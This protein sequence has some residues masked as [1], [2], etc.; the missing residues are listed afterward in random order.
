MQN[1]YEILGTDILIFD[2]SNDSYQTLKS[3]FSKYLTKDELD[4]IEK[5]QVEQDRINEIISYTIPKI[6]LAKYEN[7]KAYDVK[8]VRNINERP[9]YKDYP[10]YYYSI[11]HSDN[12]VAFAI[13]TKNIGLDIEHRQHRD[14]KALNYVASEDEIKECLNDDDKYSLWTFKEAYAKYIKKGIGKYL[15][16]INRNNLNILTKT[17]YI[18]HLVITLVKEK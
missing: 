5:Y 15:I 3:Y 4:R 2:T 16:D 7:I 11:S 17:I 10:N 18:N 1:K 13:D 12:Y 14:L 9:Y 6:E 8:I